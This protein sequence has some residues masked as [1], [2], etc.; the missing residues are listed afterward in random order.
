MCS[1]GQ[2][3]ERYSICLNALVCHPHF[4]LVWVRLSHLGNRADFSEELRDERMWRPVRGGE[5]T[6]RLGKRRTESEDGC[7]ILNFPSYGT[8]AFASARNFAIVFL[9][10]STFCRVKTISF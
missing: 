4:L 5:E 1:Q 6:V 2:R 10:R 7:L 3:D 9:M 8:D